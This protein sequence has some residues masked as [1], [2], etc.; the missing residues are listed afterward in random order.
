MPDKV[1]IRRKTRAGKG[2]PRKP[3][4]KQKQRQS[5]TVKLS[6]LPAAQGA[7]VGSSSSSS[8][9]AGGSVTVIQPA[10]QQSYGTGG[11][12][13][14]NSGNF[15]KLL[16][17]LSRIEAQ[18]IVNHHPPMIVKAERGERGER[19]EPGEASTVPGP[20]GRDSNVAGPAGAPGRDSTVPGP[21]GRDG[22]PGRD[23][24]LQPPP[25]LQP[26]VVQQ[27]P[28][29]QPP[30][31]QQDMHLQLAAIQ[32]QQQE[33]RTGLENI[34]SAVTQRQIPPPLQP[35]DASMLR[36]ATQIPASIL[37]QH[38]IPPRLPT[39]AIM[40]AGL[41]LRDSTKRTADQQLIPFGDSAVNTGQSTTSI[42]H[43]RNNAGVPVQITNGVD[44]GSAL[45]PFDATAVVARNEFNDL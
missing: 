31:Q 4:Q 9:G 34:Y 8:A 14:D 18:G 1:I 13:H 23:A 32:N 10:P 35:I 30:L 16:A 33:Q 42:T 41:G 36:P 6:S 12:D 25:V 38:P 11:L 45:V 7:G 43:R 40:G 24:V 3:L 21:P 29:L 27:P 15:N 22:L 28:V 39:Q 19:G 2:K 5:L 26:P 20:P 44:A 17:A 37:T